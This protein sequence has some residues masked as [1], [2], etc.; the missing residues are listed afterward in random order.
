MGARGL[1]VC[2]KVSHG[3]TSLLQLGLICAH[4]LGTSCVHMMTHPLGVYD[5]GGRPADRKLE[6]ERDVVSAER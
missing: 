3:R 1:V 6:Y 5:Q 4:L 2:F